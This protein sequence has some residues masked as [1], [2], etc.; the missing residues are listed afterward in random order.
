MILS[1]IQIDI[2]E[3]IAKISVEQGLMSERAHTI[4]MTVIRSHRAQSEELFRLNNIEVA[5]NDLPDLK[6]Q[7]EILSWLE[8]VTGFKREDPHGPKL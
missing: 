2:Y 8:S 3:S 5:L 1:P 6:S 7:E 4:F